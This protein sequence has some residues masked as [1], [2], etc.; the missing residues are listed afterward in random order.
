M[1][2]TPRLPALAA[3]LALTA[4]ALLPRPAMAQSAKEIAAARAAFHEGEEAEA[5]GDYRTALAR[6][7]AAIAVKST[8]QLHLRIGAV[9]EKLGKLIDALAS[10]QQGLDKAGALPAVAKV[11]KEQIEALKPRIPTVTVAIAKPPPPAGLTV[12]LD[13]APLAAS[14]FGT[15]IRVDPGPHR[16]RAAAPGFAPHEQAFNAVERGGARVELDLAPLVARGPEKPNKPAPSK[17]P[18]IVAI[19]GGGAA[20]VV[21]AA[22]IGVS[23]S[24]DGSIDA[25]CGGS[26]RLTCPLSKKAQIEGDVSTVNALRF[27]GIGV[28]VVGAAGAT[29]GAVLLAKAS[30]QAPATGSAVQ[31]IPLAG[32]GTAGLGV[33]GRF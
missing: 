31:I 7:Q 28:A 19:A 5:K 1:P 18:A 6:F 17:V 21:G 24:K 14:A 33:L 15:A 32:P 25:L 3:S 22:L 29:V 30:K 4:I 16:L 10:Y 26:D 8:P 13:D 27:A 2:P 9:Q 23:V 20:L 12:T 11:A